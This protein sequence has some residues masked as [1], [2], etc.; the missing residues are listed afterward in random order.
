MRTS[1]RELNL[2]LDGEHAGVVTQNEKGLVRFSYLETYRTAPAAYPVSLSMP[3]ASSEHGARVTQAYLAGLLPDNENALERIGL[4]HG[5]SPSNPF[6]LLAKIGRDAAGAVQILPVG[7]DPD[8]ARMRSGNIGWLT[9]RQADQ[10]VTSLIQNTDWN[11]GFDAGR[12]SLAGAQSK[13]A[14]FQGDDGRWGIPRDSTPTTH[15]LKP[16]ATAMAGHQINEFL[17]MRA[18][19]NLGLRV[20]DSELIRF[21]DNLV[22]VSKRYDRV[23]TASGWRRLH[24]EDLCQALG[25]M[26]VKKYQGD[27]GPGVPEIAEV[28]NRLTVGRSRR[29]FFDSL[30]FNVVIG[31]TDAHAKN[32]SILIA[33]G[34]TVL[35]P[36]YDVGSI[37]GYESRIP[38][39]SAMKIGDHYSFSQ[40]STR[41]WLGVAKRLRLGEDEATERLAKIQHNVVAAYRQA[42]DELPGDVD[43]SFQETGRRILARLEE[44][45]DARR[46]S[47]F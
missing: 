14:L 32:Y 46:W 29:Q 16:A 37:Y 24:Q 15:I 28:V 42:I 26:P 21:G 35:A 20:A 40:I 38:P 43:K 3:L 5:V 31:N 41:D 36:L 45:A 22:F 13:M 34:A 1:T 39:R 4:E 12:W 10:A 18:A 8:D 30:V 11:P 17:A 25:I 33:P 7:D 47:Q 2:F 44:V 19:K 27:G 9:E 6:A 23:R